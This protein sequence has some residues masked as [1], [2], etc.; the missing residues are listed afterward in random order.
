MK[1]TKLLPSEIKVHLGSCTKV[2]RYRRTRSIGKPCL[3]DP[4]AQDGP[5]KIYSREEIKEY[6]MSKMQL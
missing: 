3:I 2:H 1:E 5:V 4:M 6:E